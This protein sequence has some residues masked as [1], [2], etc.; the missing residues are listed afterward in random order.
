MGVGGGGGGGGGEVSGRANERVNANQIK[1][2]NRFLYS[3]D[4]RCVIPIRKESL[5]R[6]WFHAGIHHVHTVGDSLTTLWGIKR[7]PIRDLLYNL[8]Y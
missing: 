8:F 4:V 7:K 6:H 3:D 5:E 2:T 1:C